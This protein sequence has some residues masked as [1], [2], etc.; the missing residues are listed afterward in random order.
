MFLK[1]VPSWSNRKSCSIDPDFKNELSD[2]KKPWLWADL[3]VYCAMRNVTSAMSTDQW[4][5][6]DREGEAIGPTLNIQNNS[7]KKKVFVTH[8]KSEKFRARKKYGS[9]SFVSR[10]ILTILQS[11]FTGYLTMSF[12]TIYKNKKNITLLAANHVSMILASHF[13][14]THQ[15]V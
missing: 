13:R 9:I 4:Q 3:S 6:E 2:L 1:Y 7:V 15:L 12:T 14:L 5:A 11:W 8:Y 10:L